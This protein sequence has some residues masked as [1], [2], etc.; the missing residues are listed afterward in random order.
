MGDLAKE[1]KC[2]QAQLSLAWCIANRDVST[3]ILGAT[4]HEQV[5]DNLGA[6][7]VLRRWTPEVEKKLADILKNTPEQPLNWR[8]WQ[9]FPERRSCSVQFGGY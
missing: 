4:K 2:T 6:V 8:S 9:P 7:D 1:M 3:A 5:A